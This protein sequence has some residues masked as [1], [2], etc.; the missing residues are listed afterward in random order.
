MV[1]SL[2]DDFKEA[3]EQIADDLGIDGTIE[4]D[5]SE[6]NQGFDFTASLFKRNRG[7]D[8]WL[9]GEIR[10]AS[11]KMTA[12]LSIDFQE[13]VAPYYFQEKIDYIA[14]HSDFL[15]RWA[16]WA[17]FRFKEA[18][19]KVTLNSIFHEAEI[20]VYGIP[21]Y[22]DPAEGEADLLF[23]GIL[24]KQKGKVIIYRFRHV[25]P[26]SGYLCRSFSYA[27]WVNPGGSPPFWV[28]F[29]DNCG[30]EGG[31]SRSTHHHFEKLIAMLKRKLEVE[32]K[33]FDVPYSE[34]E[35]FLLKN[36][37]GFFSVFRDNDV[38]S[39]LH[40]HGPSEV[41]KGSEEE[42]EKF[43]ESFQRKEYP[44]ALRD[45]RALVQQAQENVAKLK[46]LDCSSVQDPD[47]NKLG[48]FLIEKKVLDG[49][50]RS[51]FSAFTSIA[52][53]ASHRNFPTIE[54]M[55][56]KVLRTRILL[57]FHLG[58]QLLEE[59]DKTVK[60]EIPVFDLRIRFGKEDDEKNS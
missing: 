33:R 55:R 21:G 27:V 15:C 20:R 9:G 17:V 58:V 54:D 51:W 26:P 10:D 12:S 3:A 57:T 32:I 22:C 11:Q 19:E 49:R 18:H 31:R 42:L 7:F 38:D 25:E 13:G 50:L 5:H 60:P 34:L 6:S 47:V 36:S 4:I 44:Q 48:A 8:L 35:T 37:T 59:L 16:A 1:M 41:L 24:T 28:T 29:P 14:G 46:E 52:N 53:L 45:L 56:D 30:L 39:L 43:K 23:H 40:Y 2:L